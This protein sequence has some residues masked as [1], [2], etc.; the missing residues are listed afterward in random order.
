V[1]EQQ[2]TEPK[3]IGEKDLVFE[4]AEFAKRIGRLRAEM[5]SRELDCVL[6]LAP[7]DIFYLTGFRSMGFFEWQALVVTHDG[8]PIMISRKLEER[9]YRNNSWA[10]RY[11]AYHD[12]EDPAEKAVEVITETV[13]AAAKV[14]LP[15]RSWYLSAARESQIRDPLP[16]V[17]WVDTTNLVGELRWVKSPAEL[18]AIRAAARLTALGMNAGIEAAA[19]GKSENDVAAEF[20]ATSIR[21]G[22]EDPSLGPY[23]GTGV[24]SSFGHSAW[25]NQPLRSGDVI[26]FEAG[27]CVKRYH[28]AAMRTI[29][30]GEPTDFVRGLEE[31]SLAGADA[32]LAALKP[33]ATSGE[34]DEACRTAVRERGLDE[35]F[36][37]RTGYSIGIGFSTWLDGFSLRPHDETVIAKDMVVHIVPFLSTGDLAVALSET[38]LVTDDGGERLVDLPREISVR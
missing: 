12:F 23:V 3:S 15:R 19:A 34:V 30:I 29:S 10:D 28:A 11:A 4:V 13:G 33:G 8:E 24:R 17:E 35:Y 20:L 5:A 32:A 38:A 37:H 7:E 26:F 9:M 14:G 21:N 22:S 16:R 1:L 18:E 31:A 27:G 6:A 36:R 2:Q 25:E